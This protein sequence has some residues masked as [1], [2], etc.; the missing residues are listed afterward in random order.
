MAYIKEL[1]NILAIKAKTVNGVDIDKKVLNYCIQTLKGRNPKLSYL[2]VYDGYNLPFKNESF[3][4]I[5]C[6]DV[7]EHVENYEILIKEMLR[8][9]KKGVFIST[10][11]RR[12]E[13]TNQDGSPKNYWHLREWNYN[14]LNEILKHFGKIE[15]NFINGQYEGPFTIS[16]TVLHDTLALAPFIIKAD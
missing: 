7:L 16:S 6:V 10:P 4:I 2:N 8:V 11:N 13:Y 5:T 14:E 15:W 1:P 12:P 9:S 3:D